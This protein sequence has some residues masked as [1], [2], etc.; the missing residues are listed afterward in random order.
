[1][2]EAE[3]RAEHV[4]PA[5]AAAGWGITP[6]S[7]IRRE[8]P[9]TGTAWGDGLGTTNFQR[10]VESGP[11]RAGSGEVGGRGASSQ[12][13]A[14]TRAS[15]LLPP[16]LPGAPGYQ[17]EGEYQGASAREARARSRAIHGPFAAQPL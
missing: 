10:G 14:P 15:A 7:R 12:A 13:W 4:D 6:G 11:P 3:T 2:N 17:G 16:S 8:Y 9:I 1:M 5:L